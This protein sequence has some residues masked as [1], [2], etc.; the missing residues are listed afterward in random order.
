MSV[1]PSAIAVTNKTKTDLPSYS[2]LLGYLAMKT[3][4]LIIK[5]E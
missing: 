4:Q 2:R 5:F 3:M 1:S